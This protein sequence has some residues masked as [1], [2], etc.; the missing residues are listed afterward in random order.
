MYR[1]FDTFSISWQDNTEERKRQDEQEERERAEQA[2]KE[3]R[4]A[5]ER[6]QEIENKLHDSRQHHYL[7]PLFNNVD[8]DQLKCEC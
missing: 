7:C 1:Y 3:E 8:D 4:E 6:R 5:R 2:E